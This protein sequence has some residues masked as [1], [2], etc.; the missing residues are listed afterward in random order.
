[1]VE[2]IAVDLPGERDQVETKKTSEFVDLR[3]RVA[4]LIR[5]PQASAVA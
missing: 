5:R 1:V 3:T 2:R 4:E